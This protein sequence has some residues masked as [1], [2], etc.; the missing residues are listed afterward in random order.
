MPNKINYLG[1]VT[2]K[3]KDSMKRSANAGT[4]FFLQE[5][6]RTLL[7][8]ENVVDNLSPYYMTIVQ[9]KPQDNENPEEKL[10]YGLYS[11]EEITGS[12]IVLQDLPIVARQ[13]SSTDDTDTSCVF[14]S[15][16]N[17][18]VANLSN[19]PQ[20][21]DDP[22]FTLLLNKNKKIL[23]YSAIHFGDI[24]VVYEDPN[25]QSTIEWKLIFANEDKEN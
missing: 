8:A 24:S 15:L 22:C 1:V 12:K 14:T 7:T 4:R 23:A 5:I 3:T 10:F 9:I 17:Y 2:I 16:F 20:T 19:K 11:E 18:H 21:D 13:S 6:C 25:A